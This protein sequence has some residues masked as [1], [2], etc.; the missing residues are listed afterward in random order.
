ME[1]P[2]LLGAHHIDK[3]GLRALPGWSAGLKHND[4]LLSLA[5][6]VLALIALQPDRL[7]IKSAQHRSM[8]PTT[9]RIEP[10]PWLEPQRQL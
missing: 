5:M 7:V 6:L 1:Q 8:K 10:G 3:K 2:Q 4:V 9:S